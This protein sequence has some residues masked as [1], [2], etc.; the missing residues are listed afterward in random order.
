MNNFLD[1]LYPPV[2]GICGK[3]N[4]FSLCK[5]C[6][7]RL[8]KQA[9]FSIDDYSRKMR[10]FSE[11]LYMFKYDGEIRKVL[12]NY[13]FNDKSYIY[14]TFVNFL[15]K[16][17][18]MCVQIKKYDIIIPV[19]ISLKRFKQR[20]YNQSALIAR[21]IASD[22]DL[23]FANS[24]LVKIKNNVAQSLLDGENREQ[25]VKNVYKLNNVK[26]VQNKNV[27]LVD[28]IYT[29]GSTVNECC[30]LLNKLN[31]KKIGVFTLAKD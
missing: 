16:N 12:L 28:D 3:V 13:K 24:V 1:I 22:M 25:N 2:C 10:F 30:R 4:K 27:L 21:Q 26:K 11:H 29:T 20:G 6:E 5:K 17:E 8:K 14:K 31:I 7:I 23:I 19:P 18:K 9:I 15:K